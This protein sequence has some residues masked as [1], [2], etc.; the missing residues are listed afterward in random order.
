MKKRYSTA[1]EKQ[2]VESSVVGEA[3]AVY[4][5]EHVRKGLPF[6]AFDELQAK[7][8]VTEDRLAGLLGISRA[9]LHRRKK[10][11]HLESAESDRLARFERLFTHAVA[12]FGD[13][14][15]ARDWLAASGL[16]FNGE[17]PLDY[18]DTEIGAQAVDRLLGR[19]EHGVFS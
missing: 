12:T 8:G 9:T 6:S 16:D 1:E 15:A 10:S 14:D 5:V 3:P 2:A 11:A 13:G 4:M 7:L 19:M 18:A 17:A